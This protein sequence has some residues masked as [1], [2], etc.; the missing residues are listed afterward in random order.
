MSD[1]I[2]IKTSTLE[3]LLSH[4]MANAWETNK[5]VPNVQINSNWCQI[6]FAPQQCIEQLNEAKG[7]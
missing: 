2:A 6:V 5:I 4:Y 7:H 1:L 3:A